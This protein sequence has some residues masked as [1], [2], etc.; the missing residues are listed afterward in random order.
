MAEN[1]QFNGLWYLR[2]KD[3]IL[4][5][6]YYPSEQ[7]GKVTATDVPKKVLQDATINSRLY[8]SREFYD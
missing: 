8:K 3:K 6:S 7:N 1:W 2:G 5:K 4:G